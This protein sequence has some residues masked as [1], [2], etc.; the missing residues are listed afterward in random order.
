MKSERPIINSNHDCDVFADRSQWELEIIAVTFGT[1][2]KLS[3]V[4]PPTIDFVHRTAGRRRSQTW[5]QWKVWVGNASF[6]LHLDISYL[7]CP[8]QHCTR[9]NCFTTG[10]KKITQQPP[11]RTLC[12][13][14]DVFRVLAKVF[15]SYYTFRWILEFAFGDV[16]STLIKL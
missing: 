7:N 15:M 11:P 9:R 13:I 4:V 1:G 6:S 8:L 3:T 16:K 12:L 14:A 5:K 2:W 10:C